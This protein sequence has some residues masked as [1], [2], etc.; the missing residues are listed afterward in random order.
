MA[1][2]PSYN[3]PFRRR[4]EGK[5]DY[6]FRRRL[7]QSGLPRLVVRCSLKHTTVQ[8]IKA[9]VDGDDV[10][11][12]A[13]SSELSKSYNWHRTC[14]NVPSA[15]LT[16]LICGY[17]AAAKGV[18][19]AVLDIGLQFPSRGARVFATLKGFLE[20]GVKVPH[21][22]SILPDEERIE[23]RHIADYAAKVSTNNE[24][25]SRIFSRYLSKDLP[26]Q[27]ISKHFSS[28]KE[29]IIASFK[30]MS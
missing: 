25:Y 29:K 21:N 1:E 10:I 27:E 13:N 28:V 7:I 9:K 19:E 23:G 18:K 30:N 24:V 4:R 11:V 22:E 26:P 15:Y 14:G 3:V 12:S 20:S 16:G 8:L 17:R 5:T 6:Q 2:G